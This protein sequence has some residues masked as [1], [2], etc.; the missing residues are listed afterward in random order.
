MGGLPK[1]EQLTFKS[2]SGS[3]RNALV[4]PVIAL[5]FLC[6]SFSV[7]TLLRSYPLLVHFLRCPY[8]S[9][10]VKNK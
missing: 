6:F 4:A 1:P 2:H 8:F 10:F 3:G 7:L 9:L 5:R